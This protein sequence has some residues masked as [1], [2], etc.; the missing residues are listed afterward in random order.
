MTT[1]FKYFPIKENHLKYFLEI[2]KSNSLNAL[3]QKI[4]SRFKN[5]AEINDFI[6][7][8]EM[9]PIELHF[10]NKF[11]SK[12]QTICSDLNLTQLENLVDNLTRFLDFIFKL[13]SLKCLYSHVRIFWSLDRKS[14]KYISVHP[15]GV[16]VDAELTSFDVII[17][18]DPKSNNVF[19]SI[20]KSVDMLKNTVEHLKLRHK[21]INPHHEYELFKRQ[22]LVN[23]ISF[24][25]V[26]I[27]ILVA[28]IFIVFLSSFLN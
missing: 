22:N 11:S 6:Q 13:A 4:R 23:K 25:S 16:V 1:K 10:C 7:N 15:H 12:I 8:G 20:V 28:M 5:E 14:F 17:T 9:F 18:Y 21:Q 26:V 19:T 3:I 2:I 24:F 27:T